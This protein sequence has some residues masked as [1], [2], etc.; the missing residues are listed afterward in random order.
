MLVALDCKGLPGQAQ[1]IPFVLNFV[2]LYTYLRVSVPHALTRFAHKM[3]Y[4]SLCPLDRQGVL[5]DLVK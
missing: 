2:P 4:R 1:R 5:W 3:L